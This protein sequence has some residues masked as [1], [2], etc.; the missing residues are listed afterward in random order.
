MTSNEQDRPRPLASETVGA[1]AR[2]AYP[3]GNV[4]RRALLTLR[5]EGLRSFGFKLLGLLGYRR[6]LLLERALDQPI[7]DATPGLPV[8]VAMLAHDEV[9]DYLVFRPGSTRREIASRLRSGD[10]CFVARHQGRIVAAAWVAVQ[11]VWVPFLGCRIDVA[12]DEAHIY[13]K[14]TL[15]AYR[16]HGIANA[17]RT[18]HLRHLQRA[19]LRR[20]TGAVLP[21]NASSLRD[22]GKGGFRAYG[23]IGRIRL[24]PWQRVFIMPPPRGRR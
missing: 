18:H 16:G 23:I 24:G 19:G 15:P 5:D 1:L 10:M 21:E 9:D 13:D 6:L 22:D 3:T 11:P 4:V 14:F 20:A 2:S 7:A 17:V 8:A 12:P